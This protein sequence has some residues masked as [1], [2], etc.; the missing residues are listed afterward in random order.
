MFGKNL[1][2]I[3]QK[4]WDILGINF[5]IELGIYSAKT[6]GYIGKKLWDRLEKT[7]EMYWG[8]AYAIYFTKIMKYIQ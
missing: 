8:K 5:R 2:C 4:L 1:G 3:G 6:M 7:N